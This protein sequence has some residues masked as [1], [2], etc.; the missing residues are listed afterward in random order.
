MKEQG[1]NEFV[2]MRLYATT[3]SNLRM[4]SALTGKRMVQ[5][6]DSIVQAELKRLQQ[7]QKKQK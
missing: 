6:L 4:L 1:E 7:A 3:R 5:I 2:T